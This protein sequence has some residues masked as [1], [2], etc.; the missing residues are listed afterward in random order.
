MKK[1]I[2]IEAL[3]AWTYRDEL[4]KAGAARALTGVGIK[5][6]YSAVEAYGEY[7]SLI[8]CAGRTA[9]A[10]WPTS[11]PWPSRPWMRCVSISRSAISTSLTIALP[12]GWDPLSD[13]EG[14]EPERPALIAR[15]LNQLTMIDADGARV[16]KG[17]PSTLVRKHAILGGCPVWEADQPERR[18]ERGVNG[19]TR[20]FRRIIVETSAGPMES[21]V[22]GW[23]PKAKRPAA[24]AYPKTYL[25]PDPAD[26]VLGR[27]EY[28][29]WHSALGLLAEQ[30]AG[31]LDGFD[32]EPSARPARPWE[33]AP[34]LAPRILP[35]LVPLSCDKPVRRKA[36]S[37]RRAA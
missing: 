4:P 18:L 31:Q 29:V 12:E 24:D 37:T 9:S 16:M 35:S 3:L 26:A 36:G 10:W 19:R 11:W 25:D 7:L 34:T 28:E 6:A 2:G 1:R 8:D 23:D 13:L 33:E 27:A 14:I 17:A 22:D 15:A 5:R 32:V 20:W 21:E 30:L